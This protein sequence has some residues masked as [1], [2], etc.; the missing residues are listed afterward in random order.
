MILLVET[1]STP[2]P[3]IFLLVRHQQRMITRAW[4]VWVEV[5]LTV[6]VLTKT[7]ARLKLL[8]VLIIK[9]RHQMTEMMAVLC[10]FF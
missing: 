10:L 1:V 9:E 7:A 5:R 6:T 4:I 3:S 8:L 2:S